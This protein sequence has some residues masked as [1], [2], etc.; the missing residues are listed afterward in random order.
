MDASHQHL[1]SSSGLDEKLCRA[2]TEKRLEFK[3]LRL[4]VQ[5]ASLSTASTKKEAVQQIAMVR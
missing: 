3:V 5:V 4:K 1:I 2:M